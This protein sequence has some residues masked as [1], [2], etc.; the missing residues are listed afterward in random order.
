M[1]NEATS[2]VT[3]ESISA[4]VAT[5][6]DAEAATEPIALFREWFAAAETSELNDPNAMAL[7]TTTKQGYPS[8][9]MVLLK[10]L[11]DEGFAFYTNV[12]SQKGREL[13]ENPR[14][15]LCLHWKSL[16]RQ[17]RIEGAVE[18]LPDE[19]ADAYFHSRSRRSQ[20]GAV[21]SQQS[22]PLASRQQLEEAARALT[23]RYADT[24]VPKPGY[25]KGFLVIPERIEFWQDG[26]DRL[27]DRVVFT[28]EAGGTWT[29]SRLYP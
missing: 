21:A 11:D 19:D 20:I 25:W 18:M 15:A 12:E 28:R 6:F 27:H 26:P 3:N 17:V 9:R 10:R 22:R 8:V 5:V 4:T 2:A 13:V 24:V 7:A 1:S 16:R 14:A 29:R 23:E